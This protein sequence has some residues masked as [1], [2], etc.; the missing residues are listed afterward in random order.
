MSN[1]IKEEDALGKAFDLRLMKRLL[2]YAKPFTGI[3]AL[4]VML[5][6]LITVTELLRPKLIQIAIDDYIK[7][8]NVPMIVY[9]QEPNYKNVEINGKYYVRENEIKDKTSIDEKNVYQL[10][11]YQDSYYIY[12]G[13]LDA[14]IE[15][16]TVTNKNNQYYVIQDSSSSIVQPLTK[17]QYLNFRK[18]DLSGITKVSLQ[19]LA[20]IALGFI[21]NYI[22]VFILYYTGQKIIYNMRKELF[23]HL[24]KLSL[25]F[26]D[27]NPVGRLVTRVTNDMEN[28][29]EMYTGVLVNLFKDVFLL[30]GII[31]VML[32]MNFKLA[33]ISFTVIPLI[34]LAAAIFRNK[35]REAYRLV[36]VKLAKINSTLSEN[37]SGMRIIQIFKKEDFKYN[38]FEGINQEYKAA[39]MK[40]LFVFAVFRPSM[41]LIYSLALALLIWYGGAKVLGNTLSFGILFAFVN[42]IDSFF[43]PIMDLTEKFNILQSAMASSERIFLLLDEEEGIK[44]PEQPIS[45]GKIKGEIEFKNVWFAYNEENWVLRDVSFK[46]KSGETA[47]FVGATGA[48][49]TSIISLIS[50]LYDIQKGEILIDGINIKELNKYELRKQI[51]TV[52]QDVFL[53]S[54]DITGNIRLNST[55]ISDEKVREV[56]Q[57]VN[58]DK[59]IER[60]PMVY[61]EEV[62]ERGA[63]LSSGQRQLLAFARALAF[64]PSILVL[65]EATSNID[66]ET[67]ILIQDAINKV[68]INRTTI[69][70]AHRLS[71]IQH[72]D[73]II[74]LHKGKIREIGTHQKLLDKK[75][76]YYDL[77]LLQYKENFQETST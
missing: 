34:V 51:G 54:G 45:P 60:L 56:A 68:I 24:Q 46:I 16:F 52:L 72:A 23:S 33:L 57:Y 14:N 13:R 64:D 61:K 59:F 35:A 12:H 5:L 49:K 58:A 47:A 65:D 20:L 32:L 3:I 29:N 43:K 53:F 75:G 22:Q 39:S 73:N 71:T 6:M 10:L 27:K 50:R 36:R 62:K 74:V 11:K 4:C 66:T 25:S 38:E 8:I 77:Y 19:F 41:D 44:S 37:I 1:H 63:T 67:E 9:D 76:M 15:N 21:F 18:Q 70:I 2:K 40:E 55:E 17:D 26:Y 42:Y 48:G 31:A 28:L 30:V 69:V 7:G